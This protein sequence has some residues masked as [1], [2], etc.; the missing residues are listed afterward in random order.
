MDAIATLTPEVGEDPFAEIARPPDDAALVELRLDL[1]ADLDVRAA[2]AACP[3]PVLATLRSEAEGGCGPD[4]P[5]LRLPVLRAA[6]EAGVALVDL[7]FARDRESIRAIGLAPEQIVLSWHDPGATP[8]DLERVA[9]AM[10]ET[11]AP[12]VK[13]VPSARALGDLERVLALYR[14]TRAERRRLV[15]FA[16]GSVGVPSR[17][18]APLLGAPI[19]YCAWTSQATAAPGQLTASRLRA[20]TGHLS[21][22]PQRL[23]GVVGADVTSSLSPQLHGSGYAALGLPYVMVPVSVPD[24]G[25]LDLLFAPA[26][27]TLFD[28]VGIEAGGWAVTTPYKTEAAAAATLA[29]PRVNRSTSANTLV[30]RQGAVLADTTDADGVVGALTAASIELEGGTA[31]VQGTGGAG[32]SAAV[33]LDLAGTDVWLRGRDDQRT[34][35]VAEAIGVRWI[36]ADEAPP[37]ASILVNATPL[38]SSPDDPLPFGEVEV[39]DAVVVVDMVYGART[40][41]LGDLAAG[42]YIDGRAVLAH[43]GFAQFAAFTGQLPP[44]EAMLSAVRREP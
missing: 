6:Q 26:G 13:L 35:G 16:M 7:E 44:K 8:D 2:V 1:F 33:G 10:L 42:R 3:L 28:R 9:A 27:A 14:R 20:I 18:L 30:L 24:P 23:F 19:T 37:S 22:P 21:G 32:R 39:E 36:A 15:A 34:R 11:S 43:Q 29:A 4:D 38:G 41:P 25:D 17:L 12:V 5:A 40:P 31:V